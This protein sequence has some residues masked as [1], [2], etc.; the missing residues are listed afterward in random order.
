[1]RCPSCAA[2]LTI[3]LDRQR[4][5]PCEYCGVSVHIPN[6]VWRQLHPVRT[7]TEWY[8]GFE[9][10]SAGQ[11]AKREEREER[12]RKRR[13][14]KENKK[15]KAE[16][17]SADAERKRAAREAEAERN[18]EHEAAQAEW[19]RKRT[20]MSVG[21]LGL[22]TPAVA[23][24]LFMFLIAHGW[25]WFGDRTILYSIAWPGPALAFDV[26]V[27][28][29]AI[30]AALPG[31]VFSLGTAAF[32]ARTGVTTLSGTLILAMAL[33]MVPIAGM[34]AAAFMTRKLVFGPLDGKVRD[35][36]GVVKRDRKIAPGWG[37]LPLVIWITGWTLGAQ[38]AFFYFSGMTVFEFINLFA[39]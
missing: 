21:G 20:F 34:I 33:G 17:R 22:A 25:L 8:V 4:V 36:A 2:G 14:D 30:T 27:C 37:A 24:S 19:M 1:M 13:E 9:G 38:G 39:D 29:I 7:V 23:L 26:I 16:K 28:A 35:H 6:A 32:K 15:R 31:L 18:A 10:E 3:A 12:K 5:T 11:R